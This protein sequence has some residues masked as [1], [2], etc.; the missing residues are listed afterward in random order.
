[1][2]VIQV[3]LIVAVF[4]PAI[5]CSRFSNELLRELLMEDRAAVQKTYVNFMSRRNL[6]LFPCALVHSAIGS[7]MIWTKILNFPLLD[8]NATR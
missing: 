5:L 2:K 1:M 6:L 4:I 7:H 3:A 8:I